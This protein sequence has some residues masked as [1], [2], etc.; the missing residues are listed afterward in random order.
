MSHCECGR[1]A[2]ARAMC[3]SCYQQWRRTGDSRKKRCSAVDDGAPCSARGSTKGLC[4]VHYERQRQ[5]GTTASVPRRDNAIKQWRV[6]VPVS[7]YLAA[8]QL[9]EPDE[10]MAKFFRTALTNEI[11]RRRVLAARAA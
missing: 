9:V 5:H 7:I 2:V 1:R 6:R 8:H 4:P 11:A 3:N 10:S